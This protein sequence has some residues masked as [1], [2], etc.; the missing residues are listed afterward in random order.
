ME[1]KIKIKSSPFLVL[2]KLYFS[3]MMKKVIYTLILFVGFVNYVQGQTIKTSALGTT[4]LDNF[5]FVGFD[6][7]GFDYFIKDNVFSKKGENQT[8]EYKNVALGKITEVDI[9]NPLKILLFYED[10]NTVIIV[11]N[12]LNEIQKFN[13]FDLDSSIFASKV[14]MAAQNKFW[15]YNALT[16]QIILFDYLNSTYKNV[17][18][19]VQE[20][21]TFTQSSFNEFYWI[22]E[23]NNW[24]SI[25]IFGKSTLLATIPV[26]DKVQVIDNDRLLFSKGDKLYCLNN[27][28]KTVYQIEIVEK[29][30]Q[31]FYFKDQIL[32]IF[33]DQQIKSFK[34]KLP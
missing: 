2:N 7:L 31:N 24:Y 3:T 23:V 17:G 12:Q 1:S 33:T 32:A 22:D 30:F 34:L 6:G 20:S 5:T 14:G 13:L 28:T 8:W 10:F 11:D 25:D 18:N 16:Q 19:P 21:V 4:S 29:T 9:I 26:F 15:I 27:V